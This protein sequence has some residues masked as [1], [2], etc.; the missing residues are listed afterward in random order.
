VP[1]FHPE[2]ISQIAEKLRTP[3]GLPREPTGQVNAPG[4]S[5]G[6]VGKVKDALT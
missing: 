3:A 4:G 5:E 1:D 6:V 2:E